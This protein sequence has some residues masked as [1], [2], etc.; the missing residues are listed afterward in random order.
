MKKNSPPSIVPL[1]Y[2]YSYLH[3]SDIPNDFITMPVNYRKK[4]IEEYE[5][6]FFHRLLKNN[7]GEPSDIEWED[8]RTG[9]KNGLP[10]IEKG[11]KEWRYYLK[12]DSG[13]IIQVGT[14]NDATYFEVNVVLH[15]GNGLFEYLNE[16]EESENIKDAKKFIDS[17]LKEAKYRGE[18]FD[19][20]KEISQGENLVRFFAENLF[21]SNY[22]C[23]E[24]MIEWV[25]RIMPEIVDKEFKEIQDSDFRIT[26]EIELS[27][28]KRLDKYLCAEESFLISGLLYYYMAIEAFINLIYK[29]LLL[30]KYKKNKSKSTRILEDRFNKLEI[31]IKLILMPHVCHGFKSKHFDTESETYKNFL[32]LRDYRNTI[33]HGNIMESANEII[34]SEYPFSY[35]ISN[36]KQVNSLFPYKKSSL[37]QE[38]LL[39]V[40]NIADE[41]INMV[42][43]KMDDNT[44]EFVKK[45]IINSPYVNFIKDKNG[46]M[47][48]Y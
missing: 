22:T 24:L 29:A 26:S 23:A 28:V 10:I 35:N 8:V 31:E 43:Q 14:I 19:L 42:L 27:I 6:I 1:N 15:T 30:D 7:Y 9:E 45:K 3:K 46:I 33:I 44:M 38:H 4:D 48:L 21:W 25:N 36:K 11:A 18:R 37:K 5:V 39:V 47:R 41:L 17:L 2:Q 20:N 13:N 16:T 34:I 12:T 40:K 32:Q